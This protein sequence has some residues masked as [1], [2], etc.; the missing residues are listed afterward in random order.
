MKTKI[1]LDC[2]SELKTE[3]ETLEIEIAQINNRTNELDYYDKTI[4]TLLEY[5]N[6]STKQKQ[7]INT[8]SYNDIF[9][10]KTLSSNGTDKSKLYDKYM[11]IV[12]NTTTRKTKN[13]HTIKLCQK[14]KIEKKKGAH[15]KK[16]PFLFVIILYA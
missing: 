15:E 9:K 5:Y 12:H 2:G 7:E 4:D 1:C 13:S 10:Q 6:P 16:D 14:C 11:K 8:I 3:I